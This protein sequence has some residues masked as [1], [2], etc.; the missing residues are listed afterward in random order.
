MNTWVVVCIV[1]A[2]FAASSAHAQGEATVRG[3]IQILGSQASARPHVVEPGGKVSH[4]LCRNPL[5]DSLGKVSGMEVSVSGL[6]RFPGTRSKKCL[7]VRTVIFQKT[8]SGN[9]V[10][11]GTLKSEGGRLV[12]LSDDGGRRELQNKPAGIERKVDSRLLLVLPK[13]RSYPDDA[14][15]L[16]V[17]SFLEHP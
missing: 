17:E 8:S 5:G 7:E 2:V 6:V 9:P 10:I 12:F 13:E 4:K 16:L 15:S 1:S 14:K 11:A 3:N